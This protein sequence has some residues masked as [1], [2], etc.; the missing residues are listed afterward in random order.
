[1]KKKEII[2]RVDVPVEMPEAQTGLTAQQ[3]A[4]RTEGGWANVSQASA[5]K[6]EREIVLSHCMTFFNLV[7]VTLA[8]FLAVT[9]SSVKNMTFLIIAFVNTAI[10]IYQEIRAKRAV[11]ALTLVAEARVRV[12]R[13][14]KKDQIPSRELVRDDVVEFHPGDQICADGMLLEGELLVNES[15]ITGEDVPVAKKPGDELMS[16]SFLV[17]GVG[18]A[19]LTQ[20]GDDS[21]A[22]RLSQEAKKNPKA[23]KSGMMRSL[24]KLI[25]VVGI[26]LIPVGLALFYQQYQV[27][28]LGLQDSAEKTTA[29]LVGMIPEGLYLLTSIAMAVS[30][31]KLSQQKVLVQDMNCIETLARVDVLCV[32]KTGTIT[33]PK[34]EV[35]NVVPLTEDAPEHL[36]Q[37]LGAFYAHGEAENDTAQAMQ[38]MFA[39][40]AGW[41]CS[42]Q[43]PFTSQTKWSAKEFE[44]R[45]A[46]LVGAP[47][48]I[49]GS[50]F[51]E[52]EEIVSEWI[53]LGY[54]VLL[55]VGYRGFPEDSRVLEDA[56]QPLALV[57]LTNRIRPEAPAIFRY[58]KEQGVTV[59]VIS[60][61]NPATAA[62]VAQRAGIQGA[63]YYIDASTLKTDQ[64]IYEAAESYTVFG[65]VTP[66]QKKKLV[67]ALKKRKHTV[68]MTGDGVN[69]VLA[70]KEADCGIAMASGSQAAS[71]VA[72]L[73]LLES[74]FSVMPSI[75][76][77]GRRVINNIQRA[78]ALFLAKNIF[79]LFL[80]CISI[81]T[82]LPYPLIP[83]HLTVISTLTI[84]VPSFFLA[85]EPNY[86][87][88]T[89]RF[90]A[91]ALRRAF[92]GGLTNIFVVL[93]ALLFMSVLGLEQAEVSTICTAI[94]AVVGLLI[95]YQTSKPMQTFRWLVW[96]SMATALMLCFT[97][98]GEFF[99]LRIVSDQAL[100]VLVTLL[101]MT[102]TVF[103]AVQRLF[104]LFDKLVLWLAK[105][106]N[107]LLRNRKKPI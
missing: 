95:L 47:E 5:G 30:A 14:G 82:S 73:V 8:V 59:K 31:L 35:A 79:S 61:D 104:D 80:S 7:F 93:A 46:F 41:K 33:E 20:V 56:L 83:L 72:K 76:D 70:M 15:L 62:D 19:R 42:R 4:Q 94:L 38:E 103:F 101:V 39:A 92:P 28:E 68:A 91:G 78:A 57:T 55:V 86:Q 89:G 2:K 106:K 58:F 99:E 49:M 27:L 81:L 65:R 66:E 107:Q 16:G 25:R 84:G 75:V 53:G 96:G 1:M 50:R 88:V 97:V 13:D 105:L 23:A 87:R 34:M 29:A 26:A 48:C 54:R 37:I 18:R 71:Q 22:A 10:G 21:F 67:Q 11:D 90:L 40:S 51:G 12:I 64:E 102:P 100:L 43:I 9:G 44:G 3:V 98:V 60:G 45:G 69:D 63:E 32:D 6:S 36:E 74:D 17:A 52:I 24:D 85:M 77:E